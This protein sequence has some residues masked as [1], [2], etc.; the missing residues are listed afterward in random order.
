MIE[1]PMRL[2]LEASRIV[3]LASVEC[4]ERITASADARQENKK[5]DLAATGQ[6]NAKSAIFFNQRLI[7]LV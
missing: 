6:A 5:A 3:E 1:L 7:Q 2:L 4:W